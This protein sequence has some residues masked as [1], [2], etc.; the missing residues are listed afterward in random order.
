MWECKIA[1]PVIIFNIEMLQAQKTVFITLLKKISMILLP[2]EV[3]CSNLEIDIR[4]IAV[5]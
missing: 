1:P 2:M 4:V 5:S 3:Y